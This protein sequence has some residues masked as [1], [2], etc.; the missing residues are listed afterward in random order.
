MGRSAADGGKSPFFDPQSPPAAYYADVATKAVLTFLF[1]SPL[2]APLR[3]NDP[4]NVWP[5]LNGYYP[6]RWF[7]AQPILGTI[8][9]LVLFGMAPAAIQL[10]TRK[11]NSANQQSLVSLEIV[12]MFYLAFIIIAYVFY[13]PSHWYF[14]RY[15][16][17]PIL[18][19]TIFGICV[20]SMWAAAVRKLGDSR[21]WF[22]VLPPFA[23]WAANSSTC[24]SF[25]A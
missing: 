17:L 25:E 6:Y 9:V 8:I 5:N 1:E 2:L 10:A 7:V 24:K 13:S 18:L 20:A 19:T 21:E 4:W 23:C 12:L 15:L 16:T 11:R 14:S 3:V 22:S